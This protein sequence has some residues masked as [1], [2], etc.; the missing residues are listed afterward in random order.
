[1]SI[2]LIRN[3]PN[4]LQARPIEN[5]LGHLPQKVYEGGWQAST[6]Q[7]LIDRIKLKLKEINL[8]FLKPLMKG[9]KAKLKSIADDGVFLFKKY[10]HSKI[11]YFRKKT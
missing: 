9:V 4:V 7:V 11:L 5:F 1:M 3:P 8:N 10:F 6:E 2:M